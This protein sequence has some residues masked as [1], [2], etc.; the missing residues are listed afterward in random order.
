MVVV[1]DAEASVVVVVAEV[2]WAD[3]V[4]SEEI[5]EVT[6][7]VVAVDTM[8]AVEVAVDSVVAIAEEIVEA[9]VEETVVDSEVEIAEIVEVSEAEI[10][11]DSV[12]D[13]AV[14]VA[15]IMPT[16]SNERM[17][18]HVTNVETVISHSDGN[19]TS[20]KLHDQTEPEAA[21]DVVEVGHQEEIDTDHI[22][23][24]TQSPKLFNS[25]F[26]PPIRSL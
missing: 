7:V 16:W 25:L 19:A 6:A 15:V 9:S 11:E 4:V 1:E 21:R 5:V 8:V 14:V 24:V 13:V 2:Q 18:G 10:E 3:V 12:E 22:E 20:A 23:Q 17:T 26:T